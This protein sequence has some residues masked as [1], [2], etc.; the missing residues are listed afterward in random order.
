[1]NPKLNIT[2]ISYGITVNLGNYQSARLDLT[3]RV[4]EGENPEDILE[5]L[6]DEVNEKL[7]KKLKT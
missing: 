1:M 2:S 3:A 7:G 5:M 6:K 4:N